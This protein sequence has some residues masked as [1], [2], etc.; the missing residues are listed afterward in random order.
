MAVLGGA[1]RDLDAAGATSVRRNAAGAGRM[2]LA[3]AEQRLASLR[4]SM[5]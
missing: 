3:V 5:A 1:E 4:S 2:K